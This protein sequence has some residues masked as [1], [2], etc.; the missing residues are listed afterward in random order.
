MSDACFC[1]GIYM[2]RMIRT[3]KNPVIKQNLFC[4]QSLYGGRSESYE[5]EYLTFPMLEKL[6]CV[7]HLFSTRTGG[8]SEGI[9]ASMNLSFTRGDDEQAVYENFRRIADVLGAEPSQIVCTDQTHTTN[10]RVVTGEDRGKGVCK[11]K[12]YTDVDGLIT[13]EKGIVLATFYADCVPLY[14][15][16]PVKEVIGLSHSGWR[17][18]A[19]GMGRVTVMRMQQEFG[20]NPSDIY[21]AIGPSICRECYEVS[22]D[23]AEAFE[24]AFEADEFLRDAHAFSQ[25][26][27]YCDDRQKEAGKCQLDLHKANW[28]ILRSAGVSAEH[29]S[30][31]DVCSAHNPDYL[32]SHRKTDGKRGNLGAFLCLVSC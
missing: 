4:G 30:V 5:L 8:V 29:I 31:T 12:D 22:R 3:G 32:F 26:I 11:Q 21:A 28:W 25:I 27:S 6:P 20:C 10:V 23:V 16:D 19:D 9:Y 7:R 18:T 17:G 24:A 1:G 14:F 2:Q 13:K 15:V